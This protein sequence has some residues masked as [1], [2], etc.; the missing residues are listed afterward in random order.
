MTTL[1]DS[2][3]D[4]QLPESPLPTNERMDR[5]WWL[6]T[7]GIGACAWLGGNIGALVVSQFSEDMPWNIFRGPDLLGECCF[8]DCG[9]MRG[10]KGLD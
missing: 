7:L 8:A 4:G 9:C 6:T 3:F 2:G 5:K 10:E 1:Q